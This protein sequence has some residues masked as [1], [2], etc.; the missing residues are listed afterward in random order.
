MTFAEACGVIDH[1]TYK[2][3]WR[4]AATMPEPDILHLTLAYASVD[5]RPE[6]AGTTASLMNTVRRPLSYM[7]G[8][9]LLQE[10]EDLIMQTE[11][12]EA[13]EW[14][15][16]RGRLL[17]NPHNPKGPGRPGLPPIHIPS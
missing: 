10:I 17:N 4:F 5:A 3:G 13:Q 9:L 1:I 14:L 12:H 11:Q 2:P 16:Y 15:R 8:E 7:T 6:L